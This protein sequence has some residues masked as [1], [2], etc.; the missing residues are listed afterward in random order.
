MNRRRSSASGSA[1][2]NSR[3]PRS[4]IRAR[5]LEAS[6][7]R[8]LRRTG[9]HRSGSRPRGHHRSGAFQR[10]AAH[11]DARC[12]TNCR[13]RRCFA[14]STSRRRPSGHGLDKR[15]TG[16]IAVRLRRRHLRHLHPASRG[17]AFQVPSTKWHTHL[18]ATIMTCCRRACSRISNRPNPT[19]AAPASVAN[20][21][22]QGTR[23]PRRVS[24]AHRSVA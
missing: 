10:C 9:R 15:K 6:R 5:E 24:S 2:A 21:T 11:G 17:R 4:G 16:V 12:R 22:A 18:A 20:D 19:F 3:L 1:N 13:P 14:S 8:I 23:P 7:R